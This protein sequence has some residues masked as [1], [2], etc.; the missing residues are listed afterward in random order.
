MGQSNDFDFGANIGPNDTAMLFSG[1]DNLF[2]EVNPVGPSLTTVALGAQPAGIVLDVPN[3]RAY[4]TDKT[5]PVLSVVDTSALSLVTKTPGP[6]GSLIDG[7][8]QGQYVLAGPTTTAVDPGQIN[9]AF[10][11]DSSSNAITT[12][13]QAAATTQISVNPN[14]NV[15]YFVDG[16]QWIAVDLNSGSRLYV[17]TD[18]SPTGTDT[19]Q[20]SGVYVNKLNNQVWLAGKCYVRKHPCGLRRAVLCAA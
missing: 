4:I 15:G 2:F 5:A 8:G 7:N 19:C 12:L 9:G 17:V 16:N 13:L 20:M 10:L 18:I 6:G 14:P 11:Y 3:H 1:G